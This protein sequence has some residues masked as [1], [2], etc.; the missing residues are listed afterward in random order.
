MSKKILLADDSVTIQK[1]ISI[2][3]ASEDYEL[4]IVSD[5]DAAVRKAKEAKPDLIMA[6]VAMPGK[7]G[8]EVCEAVKSDPA[9]RNTPVLLLAGTFEPLDKNEASRV[10]ADDSIIKPFESQELIDKVTALLN[11][12]EAR[13]QAPKPAEAMRVQAAEPSA[14]IWEAGDFL[15]FTEEFAEE[16]E[17]DKGVPELDFLDTGGLFEEPHKELSTPEQDFTD[18]EFHEDELKA[19]PKDRKEEPKKEEFDIAPP[20]AQPFEVEPFEVESFKTES[21][22]VKTEAPSAESYGFDSTFWA[23]PD[24]KEEPIEAFELPGEEQAPA[25]AR[26]FS[27]EP[28]APISEVN[29]S[30]AAEIVGL[31]VEQAEERAKEAVSLRPEA[32]ALPK[33]EVARIVAKVA[34]EVVER[35]AWEVVP[36]LAEELIKAEI[37]RVKEALT[38]IK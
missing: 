14:D 1:V 29:E 31:A 22:E 5:G 3:F 20:K 12:A 8:Y 25:A 23:E 17:A 16:K 2:T 15:G 33:E 27:G 11:R 24:K 36:E 38:R 18:L 32:S 35:I 10:G 26:D 6:D 30:P 28:I 4:T 21:F 34:R 19:E 13:S 9:L 37:N 7:N